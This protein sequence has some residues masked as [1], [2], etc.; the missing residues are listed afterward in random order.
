MNH[1]ILRAV[2]EQLPGRNP[3]FFLKGNLMS[4]LHHVQSLWKMLRPNPRKTAPARVGGLFCAPLT[5]AAGWWR[6]D[7]AEQL[8]NYQSWVYAAVNAIAQE[9]ARQRPYLYL[10]TGQAE[11]EHLPLP[12]QHPLCRLLEHPN[13][14]LTP[15][16]M[17]YLTVVY[18]ELTGNCFWYLAESTSDDRRLGVPAEV[19]IVP[20]PWV[21]VIPDAREFVK[22]YAIAA[23]GMPVQT[24]A[25]SEI[26]HLKYPNPLDP[27]YGLSPLQANALTVDANTE[28]LKSRYQTFLAGPRPGVVLQTEQ[29]LTD[30]TVQ[31]LEDKLTEKFSGRANW[32]R[33]MIL[34]QGLTASPWTLTPAEMD[35]LNSARMTRD[36]I[37][38]IF[39]VPPA[40]TGIVEN[41]GLG[42]QIWFGSRIMFCEG[43]I[44]P[45]LDLIG[46]ALTRD[47]GCR[48][49]PDV[50]ITFP[51]C[52]PRVLEER[53]KDDEID[54]RLGLRTYNEIRRGRGLTPF[55]DPQFDQPL[56]PKLLTRS[57]RSIRRV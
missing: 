6:D 18:L 47:L 23:P 40:I 17:W 19:W 28:L 44:Q 3:S 27:H 5:A 41:L 22:G 1:R 25:P 52:S 11:H 48:Y 57:G 33:P 20:T 35:Y 39:R 42:G 29:T 14:W 9:I 45:K 31:R 32:H 2:P 7:P 30:Q 10:N 8:R 46:Q 49:G 26:I 43:T 53:R 16:E 36:E 55:T 38:A 4:L 15:W 34:E 51:D 21:K 56:L 37:L 12:H 50:V 13:P 24:F 54:A